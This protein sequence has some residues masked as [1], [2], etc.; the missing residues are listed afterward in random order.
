MRSRVGRRPR[1]W[2]AVAEA[3][4]ERR[5]A[6]APRHSRVA[7][8][9]RKLHARSSCRAVRQP[10]RAS[11]APKQKGGGGGATPRDEA[12]DD[13]ETEEV[14]TGNKRDGADISKVTDFVE[15]KELDSAKASQAI[16][17]ITSSLKVDR[18]AELA[19]ERELAAVS[20]QQVCFLCRR[21]WCTHAAACHGVACT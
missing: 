11:M 3:E 16:A 6:C 4:H 5:R 1:T 15:Q 7:G 9:P 10:Q 21:P 13:T 12:D 20:I 2:V 8:A 17:S 14:Q 19:R 18:E